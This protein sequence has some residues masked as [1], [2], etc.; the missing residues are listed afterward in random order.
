MWPVGSHTAKRPVLEGMFV[1]NPKIL[2]ADLREAKIYHDV[3]TTYEA[4]PL[5]NVCSPSL[6]GLHGVCPLTILSTIPD[7][8]RHMSNLIVRAQHEVFIATNYWMHSE[9]SRLI[10]NALRELS[11][12]SVEAKRQIVVRV[13]YDR[14]SVKQVCVSNSG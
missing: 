14:G 5:T 6:T 3:L 13:L 11:R 7:I 1:L 2:A 12:R 8:A 9:P 4:D 10:A